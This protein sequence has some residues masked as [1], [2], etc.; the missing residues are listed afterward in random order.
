MPVRIFAPGEV[1]AYSKYGAAL[2]GYLV[3]RVSG[4]PF[5]EY[6]EARVLAPLGMSASSFRQPLPP[7]PCLAPRRT[8]RGS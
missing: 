1:S 4:L 5:E 3:E 6:V 8:W 7:A 2:A